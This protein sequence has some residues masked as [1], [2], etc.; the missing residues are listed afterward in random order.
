MNL[1]ITLYSCSVILL[2]ILPSSSKYIKVD[3]INHVN[4]WT[5]DGKKSLYLLFKSNINKNI[6][7]NRI[8]Y[9]IYDCIMFYQ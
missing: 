7:K 2:P 5:V 1:A 9:V 6:A 3:V 8:E 4:V